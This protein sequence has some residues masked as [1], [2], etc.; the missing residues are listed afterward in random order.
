MQRSSALLFMVTHTEPLA[1]LRS[2]SC[3][4]KGLR[5]RQRVARAQGRALLSSV[6]KRPSSRHGMIALCLGP[7][8]RTARRHARLDEVCT[9]KETCEGDGDSRQ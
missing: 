1:L 9:W 6:R 8:T 5:V 2:Y 4:A 7:R 3:D